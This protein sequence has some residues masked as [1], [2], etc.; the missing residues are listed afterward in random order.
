MIDFWVSIGSTYSYLT[1]MRLKAVEQETGVKFRWRPY[2][3]PGDNDRTEEHSLRRQAGQ[4]AY[5]WRD[6][7]RR[8][9]A[10]GLSPRLPAPYP[11]KEFDLANRVA[12]VGEIEGRCA[13]HVCAVYQQ[14]FHVSRE[15]DL[16]PGLSAGCDY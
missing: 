16:E 7:E 8:A 14:W 13:D 1:V 12:V 10:R 3:G 6:I 5:M 9:Q 15:P 2:F 4:T 11:L